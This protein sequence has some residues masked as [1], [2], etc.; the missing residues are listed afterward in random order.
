M[1]RPNILKVLGVHR[2][3][4]VIS[5]LLAHYYNNSEALRG[6]FLKT[7]QVPRTAALLKGRAHTRVGTGD[8][9]VPDLVLVGRLPKQQTLVIIEN[10]L[11]AGEGGT[12]T[13]RYASPACLAR[14]EKK[15]DLN[16]SL[17]EAHYRYLTLFPGE[18]PR[19]KTFQPVGYDSFLHADWDRGPD[20]SSWAAELMSAWL[21]LVREFYDASKLALGRD[22]LVAMSSETDLEG[23]FLLFRRFMETVQ[24]PPG[25]SR[26]RIARES[27]PGRRYYLA[28]F[29]RKSWAPVR[30]IEKGEKWHLD[31]T[32]CFDIHIQPQY[33]VFERKFAVYL[34][35]E[36]NPYHPLR[37]LEVNLDSSDY[38][39][40]CR[41]RNSFVEQFRSHAPSEVTI[42]GRNNQIGKISCVG[43]L[44]DG[45]GARQTVTEHRPR[46]S[47]SGLH[48]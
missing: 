26:R 2:K 20:K 13:Q 23:N 15:F 17:V 34:H 19:D 37:W 3:E 42:G 12:Q 47:S 11:G 29:G 22:F 9:G 30:M 33:D 6:Q 21:Q 1:N 4:D 40:Y 28:M 45:K 36:T 31:R 7:I 14:L 41:R 43:G 38:T 10:K 25:R 5:N 32:D 48:P 18:N 16:P 24:L 27:R 39:A 46:R 35:Y 8:P 44:N